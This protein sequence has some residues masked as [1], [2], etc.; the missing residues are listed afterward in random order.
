MVKR[1]QVDVYI[2]LVV[3]IQSSNVLRQR[4]GQCVALKETV[5]LVHPLAVQM[6]IQLQTQVARP[7]LPLVQD[8]TAMAPVGQ[9]PEP[10]GF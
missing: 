1:G 4:V 3:I 8:V 6:D 2:G 5:A 7:Q 9:V 10:A